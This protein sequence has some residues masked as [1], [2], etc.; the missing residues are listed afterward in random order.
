MR[1]VGAVPYQ[2]SLLAIDAASARRLLVKYAGRRYVCGTPD[3]ATYASSSPCRRAI[4]Y[5]APTFWSITDWRTSCFRCARGGGVD[6]ALLE[7]DLPWAGPERQKRGVDPIEGAVEHR[8]I[9]ERARDDLERLSGVVRVGK[10]GESLFATADEGAHWNPLLAQA[11][12]EVAANIA[13]RSGDKDSHD[14]FPV[15]WVT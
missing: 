14:V 9:V 12:R 15:V 1:P 6:Q 13:G 5:V 7:R 10:Q 3:A 4:S 2:R 8:R 11:L